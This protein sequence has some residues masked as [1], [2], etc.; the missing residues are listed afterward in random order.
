MIG[1]IFGNIVGSR[2]TSENYRSV[3]FEML[4]NENRFTNDAVN[5]FA[6]L[7]IFKLFIAAKKADK[8]IPI[9]ELNL[10]FKAYC[11]LYINGGFEIEFLNNLLEVDSSMLNSG[12]SFSL[13][14]FIVLFMYAK[15]HNIEISEVKNFLLAVSAV[16][17]VS[18]HSF[19]K[20]L[21]LWT[22]MF[23]A[24]QTRDKD[25]IRNFC[26]K[27]DIHIKSIDTLRVEQNFSNSHM[28][29][30]SVALSALLET[31]SFYDLLRAVVSIG[32]DTDTLT[33]FAGAIGELFYFNKKDIDEH[34][35][36][37][38]VYFK[39]FDSCVFN[40]VT[41]VYYNSTI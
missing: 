29:C 23:Y 10:K 26:I 4:T 19:S 6:I 30:T 36:K 24:I 13:I 15:N 1:A 12:Q 16:E 21:S 28:L 27:H 3:H 31:N 32:G 17:D 39:N 11:L 9:R 33:T 25:K 35:E 8:M 40:I 22:D 34:I 14:Q 38:G 20:N 37:A 41:D 2:F 5:M 7:E 18:Y